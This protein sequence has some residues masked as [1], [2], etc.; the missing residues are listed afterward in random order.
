MREAVISVRDTDLE[1]LGLG[2]LVRR[3]RSAGIRDFEE[4]A[5]HGDYA[6][7]Q[8]EVETHLDADRLR[9]LEYVTEWRAVDTPGDSHLYLVAF[10]VPDVSESIADHADELVGTCDPD[11]G[12]D[13][14]TM[15]LVGP[16]EAIRDIIDEY[17]SAGVSPDIRK[18]GGYEGRER[19]GDPLTDRQREVVEAAYERGF[20]EVPRDASTADVA[21]AL[22]LDPSTV[23]EHLQRAERNLVRHALGAGE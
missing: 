8:V 16:Q 23:A 18:L 11:L 6:V 21:A 3:C 14:A 12:D 13:D 2:E 17:E 5:C 9:S 10:T 1:E 4:F 15:S 19:S 22:D 7:V 20:Y